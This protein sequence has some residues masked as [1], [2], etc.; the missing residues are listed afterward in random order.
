MAGSD[1]RPSYR[2]QT[3]KMREQ[4]AEKLIGR[5][6]EKKL[7]ARVKEIQSRRQQHLK[8]AGPSRQQPINPDKRTYKKPLPDSDNDDDCISGSDNEEKSD[9]GHEKSQTNHSIT[10]PKIIVTQ[11]RSGRVSSSEEANE[12]EEVKWQPAN[13]T[14]LSDDLYQ[15]LEQLDES[16]E[17]VDIDMIQEQLV[18]ELWKDKHGPCVKMEQKKKRPLTKDLEVLP[19]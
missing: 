11:L 1:Y 9:V 2:M 19:E 3:Q 13:D 16:Q 12:N 8:Y 7:Q 10:K 14:F 18:M 5:N 15:M 6:E 17:M 4:I